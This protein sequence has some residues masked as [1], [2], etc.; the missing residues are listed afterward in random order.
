MAKNI[1]KIKISPTNLDSTRPSLQASAAAPL[2][3]NFSAFRREIRNQR[4]AASSRRA[5]WHEFLG[6]HAKPQYKQISYLQPLTILRAPASLARLKKSN[7]F[8]AVAPTGSREPPPPPCP[9]SA[10]C[11]SPPFSSGGDNWNGKN[12]PISYQT[13]ILA[14]P[15]VRCTFMHR[16]SR[17]C[18]TPR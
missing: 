7:N 13:G 8:T 9:P 6:R 12:L 15:R 1:P 18:I 16:R 14:Q 11:G 4:H 5:Q 3:D 10:G 2:R 17:A